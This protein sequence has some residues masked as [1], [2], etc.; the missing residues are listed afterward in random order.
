V[1]VFARDWGQVAP[2]LLQIWFWATPIVYPASILPEGFRGLLSVNP[3]YPLIDGYQ[4]VLLHGMRPDIAALAPTALLAIIF[5][6][7]SLVL[8]RRAADD[9]VEAL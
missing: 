6:A 1:N 4:R 3:I 7:L 5:G 2:V 9:I 8:F